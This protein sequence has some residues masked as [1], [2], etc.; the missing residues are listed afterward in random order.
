MPDGKLLRTSQLNLESIWPY[1][2]EGSMGAKLPKKLPKY[3]V[4]YSIYFQRGFWSSLAGGYGVSFEDGHLIGFNASG[5]PS[6]PEDLRPAIGKAD[7]SKMYVLPL[8]EAQMRELF[9]PYESKEDTRHSP[10][11][12]IVTRY[13]PD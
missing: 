9:G 5:N 11:R 8:S 12:T 6:A 10:W 13:P 2:F 7:D 4:T 3:G 1:T